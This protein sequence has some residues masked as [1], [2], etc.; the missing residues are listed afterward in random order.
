MSIVPRAADMDFAHHRRGHSRLPRRPVCVG[1]ASPETR[2]R[3]GQQTLYAGHVTSVM[4]WQSADFLVDFMNTF[5]VPE[6]DD[7]LSDSRAAGWLRDHGSRETVVPPQSLERLRRAREGLRQLALAN[8]TVSVDTA[9]LDL[10]SAAMTGTAVQF[11]FG[12][13]AELPQFVAP[14]GADAAQEVAAQV[15][16]AYFAE[17][18]GPRWTRIKACAS[19]DCRYAFLDRSRNTSRRWCEMSSCGNRVKN[20]AWRGRQQQSKDPV[21]PIVTHRDGLPAEVGCL[22][23]APARDATKRHHGTPES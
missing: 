6:Q 21:G 22:G 20:R 8:N 4:G 12:G 9:V 2:N 19:P 7:T 18:R 1:F 14:P 15:I 10:A 16:G 5:Y 23:E 17:R 11:R 13:I 3:R